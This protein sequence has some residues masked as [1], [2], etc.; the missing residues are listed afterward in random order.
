[1]APASRLRRAVV[2]TACCALAACKTS[3]SHDAHGTPSAPV[4]VSSDAGRDPLSPVEVTYATSPGPL[5][6]FLYRPEGQGPFPAVIFNHG[7]ERDPADMLDEAQ[8]YVRHGFILFAPHRRGQGLS[9]AAG[10]YIDEAWVSADL[11]PDR[12]VELLDAQ[13]DDVAAAVSYLRRLPDVEADRVALVGCSYGG[14][15]TL[16]AAE[17]DL[18]LRAAIDF[19]G[20]S[21][22]WARV[23]P[24][25]ERMKRAARRARVPVFFL[26]AENDVDT[27][28][29]RVLSGEMQRAGRPT[30]VHI[31]PPNGATA[32]DGHMFCMG[33]VDP[34]WR[35]EVLD[36]L[37][38]TMA[39]EPR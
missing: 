7:S 35:P 26:Q 15:E 23:P 22:T 21:M 13:V 4:A 39:S 17:R 34:P 38:E 3:A 11:Q 16:L 32:T 2:L 1:M 30:R 33:S 25:Q 29:S 37:R 14:I 28:P 9:A 24:L 12:L 10:E 31:F 27:A 6:G 19:A 18:G 36:F 8:F 5:R 20:A